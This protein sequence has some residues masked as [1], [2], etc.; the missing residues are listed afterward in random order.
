LSKRQSTGYHINYK[1]GNLTKITKEKDAQDVRAFVRVELVNAE[2]GVVEEEIYAEN[3][4]KEQLK[5]LSGA[6]QYTYNSMNNSTYIGNF[7]DS[8]QPRA[9]PTLV[10][11]YDPTNVESPLFNI[12]EGE[13]L[14]WADLQSDYGGS[15]LLRGNR[16]KS[17]S[18]VRIDPT[19][20]ELVHAASV[21]F[22]ETRIVGKTINKIGLTSV[23]TRFE[24]TANNNRTYS[25]SMDIRHTG[26]SHK[27]ISS[28]YVTNRELRFEFDFIYDDY[29]FGT[30]SNL[31]W[32]Y[33]TY[34]KCS[35]SLLS[36]IDANLELSIFKLRIIDLSVVPEN[37]IHSKTAS[38]YSEISF[39]SLDDVLTMI[40]SSTYCLSRETDRAYYC[41]IIGDQFTIREF[42]M[43]SLS[44]TLP[45]LSTDSLTFTYPSDVGTP[46][47]LLD[48]GNGKDVLY[49]S[50]GRPVKVELDATNSI[51]S[52]VQ[53]DVKVM[54]HDAVK[55]E[56][57]LY[58]IVS[59]KSLYYAIYGTTSITGDVENM[60]GGYLDFINSRFLETFSVGCPN[61]L[62]TSITAHYTRMTTQMIG[63][64]TSNIDYRRVSFFCNKTGRVY[65]GHEPSD[66]SNMV[67]G[68]AIPVKYVPP[69]PYAHIDVIPDVVK[70]NTQQLRI[71]YEIRTPAEDI[72][73]LG[74]PFDT[75][76][77]PVPGTNFQRLGTRSTNWKGTQYYNISWLTNVTTEIEDRPRLIGAESLIEKTIF[78][79]YRRYIQGYNE[80]DGAGGRQ[81]R[82]LIGSNSS[83]TE[84]G[85]YMTEYVF[86]MS[87]DSEIIPYE[88][89]YRYSKV[90]GEYIDSSMTDAPSFSTVS[91]PSETNDLV[92]YGYTNNAVVHFLVVPKNY[93]SY[94]SGSY[95]RL[96]Y[97]SSE[98]TPLLSV[99]LDGTRDI[100]NFLP[101]VPTDLVA[102]GITTGSGATDGKIEMYIFLNGDEWSMNMKYKESG[103][104][105]MLD[106]IYILPAPWS[107]GYQPMIE[108]TN[109]SAPGVSR[110]NMDAYTTNKFGE[111][112]ATGPGTFEVNIQGAATYNSTLSASKYRVAT[113]GSSVAENIFSF[114][115]TVV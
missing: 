63:I 67:M 15:D 50:N 25:S 17:L 6:T 27:L 19:T 12:D 24:E 52:E 68:I 113:P 65:F 10:L 20:N 106:H 2:T 77:D 31:Q 87:S 111:I 79:G 26:A 98:N 23:K 58:M 108:F 81:F 22:D 70:T 5:W 14:G 97:L 8:E 95:S 21:I 112:Y 28:G 115:V 53:A 4:R 61:G 29:M 80:P 34:A 76:Y 9:L 11:M 33:P 86:P 99:K 71:T 102:D 69:S 13:V 45:I 64:G 49:S 55:M 44:G 51:L 100:K 83:T 82:L 18:G 96:S 7:F 40:P 37:Y 39:G 36:I 91:D 1:D 78:T 89:S 74:N 41:K 47:T 103:V 75:I 84:T 46:I 48:H 56:D 101:A 88:T 30:A 32:Q 92:F 107:P 114:I 38:S 16:N 35:G 3:V 62:T 54:I 94:S 59:N 60:S 93:P 110:T 43:S 109:I 85:M 90:Y 66:N 105:E 42:D 104:G 72:T 57:G 73:T